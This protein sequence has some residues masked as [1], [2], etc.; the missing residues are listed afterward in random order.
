MSTWVMSYIKFHIWRHAKWEMSFS[1][2][3]YFASS[4]HS[5]VILWI[6]VFHNCGDA[7]RISGISREATL[8]MT[9][10]MNIGLPKCCFI[11]QCALIP[12]GK[13]H[14][15]NRKY[16]HFSWK[17]SWVHIV[18]GVSSPDLFSKVELHIYH[19]PYIIFTARL[20]IIHHENTRWHMKFLTKQVINRTMS[21]NNGVVI[22]VI[23]NMCHAA[24]TMK[25]V[26]SSRSIDDG[27]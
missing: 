7:L 13:Y 8:I 22:V 21:Y 3:G 12:R 4:S 19:L 9:A 14:F 27:A 18:A 23:C 2:H 26:P 25:I 10:V 24:V 20:G 17:P 11:A 15:S 6:C 5:P 1:V 16:T